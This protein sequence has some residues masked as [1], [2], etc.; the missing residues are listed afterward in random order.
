MKYMTPSWSPATSTNAAF[1][2][3]H[4]ERLKIRAFYLHLTGVKGSRLPSSLTL[5]YLPR[6]DGISAMEVNGSK[7]RSGA[8]GIVS[9]DRVRSNE[10]GAVFVNRD[11]VRA[12]D[13]ARF[14][15][16]V[17]DEKVVNGVFR[18]GVDGWRIECRC[19]A[20]KATAEACEVCIVGE[21]GVMV[22]EKVDILGK[23]RRRKGRKRFC[24]RLEEIPEESDGCECGCCEGGEECDEEETTSSEEEDQVEAAEA[25]MDGWDEMIV[26]DKAGWV[27]DV[28][29]LVAC[30]GVGLLVSQ[31]SLIRSL[32]RSKFF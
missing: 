1:P 6:I 5:V 8:P 11:R 17:G 14:E 16:Y 30:V 23:V 19:T 2:S 4:R 32:R 13:C 24:S 18:W 15:A 27:A 12:G 20:E 31:A 21:S 7:V 3:Y 26:P 28:G 22:K 29:L 10:P 9:L 25:M